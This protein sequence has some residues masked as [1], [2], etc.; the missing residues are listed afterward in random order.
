[1]MTDS[2]SPY[3]AM[4]DAPGEIAAGGVVWRPGNGGVEVLL[5]HR[6][7]YGD[8]TFPKGKLE[9]GESVLE[10]AIREVWEEAGV[11]AAVGR[12]LGRISYYRQAGVLKV[13]D[14]WAMRAEHVA[15]EPSSEVD[16]IQWV[17]QA[18]LGKEVSYA[19]ERTVVARLRNSWAGPPDRILLTRHA[20]AGVRGGFGPRDSERPLSNRGRLQAQALV[21]QLRCFEIDTIVTS[22]ATRCRQTVAALAEARELTPE[23]AVGLWEE[24]ATS[25]VSALVEGRPAGTSLF[26]SH[27]PIIQAALR[28]L[29]GSTAHPPFQKGSTWVFDFDGA[30]LAAANY[31]AAP[32]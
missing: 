24:A 17:S 19:S 26:C 27:R 29:L 25:E 15:F 9:G 3:P 22:R 16:R 11:T 8:W 31:L 28:H 10:C 32:S 18:S 30:R 13:V 2:Y 7:K 20:I 12:Y 14:Y 4:S 21:D 5:V 6:P 1:M 23:I